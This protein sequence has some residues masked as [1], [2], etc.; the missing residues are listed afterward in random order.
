LKTPPF[1]QHQSST[2]IAGEI[3]AVVTFL[4]L[5]TIIASLRRS[6]DLPLIATVN[7]LFI[8]AFEVWVPLMIWSFS[9]SPNEGLIDKLKGTKYQLITSVLILIAI[10]V[11]VAAGIYSLVRMH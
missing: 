4:M 10:T 1:L 6:K 2:A 9:G 11:G 5:P 8:Y 7:I 3:F